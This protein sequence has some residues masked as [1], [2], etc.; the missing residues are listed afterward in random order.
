MKVLIRADAGVSIG[1]GH[2]ARMLALTE[3]LLRHGHEVVME[4]AEVT[5]VAA[6][7]QPDLGG[8]HFRDL[9][10]PSCSPPELFRG[11]LP[12][13]M[14]IDGYHF[15]SEY[16]A[17]LERRGVPYVVVDDN[18]ET[19]AERPSIVVNQNP[20]AESIDYTRLDGSRRLLGLDYVQLR[21]SLRCTPP[22]SADQRAIFV[23]FG[24]SDAGGHTFAVV[25]ELGR[26][27]FSVC[28]VTSP[29]GPRDRS[30]RLRLLE[31]SLVS[32]VDPDDYLAALRSSS[33][34]VIAA[35]STLWEMAYLGLPSVSVIVARNQ[36]RA[37]AAACGLGFTVSVDACS[38]DVAEDIG[39]RCQSISE[40]SNCWYSMAAAGRSAVDGHGV[41]RV[42]RAIECL[43]TKRAE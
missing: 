29:L 10:S 18:G 26:R 1:G 39:R 19:K 12:D 35:G 31:S 41:D 22:A 15:S 40:N 20:H 42:V 23:S 32:V 37:S 17:S 8:A 3:G 36:V 24:A 6:A 38:R 21:N 30:D 11:G 9:A 13:V 7:L 33:I 25:E 43:D 5:R 27:G 14:V 34:A 4:G 28:A 16:F 2:V